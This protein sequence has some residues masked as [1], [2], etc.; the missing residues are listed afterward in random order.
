MLV[1]FLVPPKYS[2]A[3]LHI[4]DCDLADSGLWVEWMTAG[5]RQSHRATRVIYEISSISKEQIRL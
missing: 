2:T 5:N 1:V 4:E 3:T